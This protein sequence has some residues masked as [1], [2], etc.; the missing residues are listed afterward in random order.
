MRRG[1]IETQ[2]DKATCPGSRSKFG[3]SPI[4]EAL[5]P[6]FL[7]HSGNTGSS[8]AAVSLCG[9]WVGAPGSCTAHSGP[10]GSGPRAAVMHAFCTPWICV[11]P[12]GATREPGRRAAAD[13]D[14]VLWSQPLWV[15]SWRPSYA[16]PR[17][18][19]NCNGT[20]DLGKQL[21][22]R[23][24]EEMHLVVVYTQQFTA[25]WSLN[26][27]KNIRVPAAVFPNSAVPR[28][29]EIQRAASVFSNQGNHC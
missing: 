4:P 7:C 26:A 16:L 21:C 15:P 28:S 12:T 6:G 10:L 8:L 1:K 24:S 17:L 9:G 22:L 11:P 3:F 2:K 18:F 23:T 5:M 29:G 20:L 14:R 25:M 27:S 19:A 13:W